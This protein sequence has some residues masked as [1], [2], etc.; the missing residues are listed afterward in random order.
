MEN[1]SAQEEDSSFCCFFPSTLLTLVNLYML[2]ILFGPPGSGK[3]TI[4]KLMAEKF[5]FCFY[6]GDDEMTPEEKIRVSNGS[7]NDE[8]R[9]I[10]LARLG[11]HLSELNQDNEKLV[12]SVALTRHWMRDFLEKHLSVQPQF[13]L[14]KSGLKPNEVETLVTSRR[15]NEGHPITLESFRRFTAAFEQPPTN[16]C[17]ELIN[18]QKL[19]DQLILENRLIQI[20]DRIKNQQI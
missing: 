13:V 1:R 19:E 11:H 3:T 7:W 17:Q 6:D 9:H 20:L 18:P 14:I 5:G 10:L 12:C 15:E 2:I 4:G 16:W 8:D